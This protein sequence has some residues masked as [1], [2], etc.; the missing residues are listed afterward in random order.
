[1]SV[2][3]EGSR[4]RKGRCVGEHDLTCTPSL[5]VTRPPPGLKGMCT[6][7]E[8]NLFFRAL[9][10]VREYYSRVGVLPI[11]VSENVQGRRHRTTDDEGRWRQPFLRLELDALRAAGYSEVAWREVCT[12]D[13][14]VPNPKNHVLVVANA[15]LGSLVGPTLFSSV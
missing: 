15:G 2:P 7:Q 8:S 1:M 4:L 11:I 6:V 14:G 13:F 12:Q 10:K 3:E 9:R 5:V